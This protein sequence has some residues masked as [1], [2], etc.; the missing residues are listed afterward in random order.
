MYLRGARFRNWDAVLLKR[1]LPRPDWHARHE[2]AAFR[3]KHEE[4]HQDL[5]PAKVVPAAG[6]N[7]HV[8]ASVLEDAPGQPSRG[9]APSPGACN[10]ITVWRWETR[11]VWRAGRISP[12]PHSLSHFDLD[13]SEATSN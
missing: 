13:P 6:H 8:H 10:V 9:P 2:R 5:P 11:S 4:A 3:L 7:D 1:V 12:A